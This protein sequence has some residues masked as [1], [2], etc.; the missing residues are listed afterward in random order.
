[1]VINL[2]ETESKTW[3]ILI[4]SQQDIYMMHSVSK[5][6]AESLSV[7]CFMPEQLETPR[8]VFCSNVI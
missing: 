7:T 5:L 2:S 6:S 3:S 1:M 4:W 8:E